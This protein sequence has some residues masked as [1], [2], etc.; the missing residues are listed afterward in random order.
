MAKYDRRQRKAEY[1]FIIYP[2]EYTGHFDVK[3]E[4]GSTWIITSR[5]VEKYLNLPS[6]NINPLLQY[7]EVGAGLGEFTPLVVRNNPI[8]KPIVIDPANYPLMLDLLRSAYK[9]N[10]KRELKE[11]IGVLQERCETLLNPHK[12]NLINLTLE[13]ALEQHPELNGIADV[14]VD[15]FGAIHYSSYTKEERRQAI[16]RE[17]RLTKSG[18][19]VYIY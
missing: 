11:R 16:F 17:R 12:V 2:T 5:D 7:L 13:Q 19:R 14:V 10:L 6:M 4:D 9:K 15:N 18:R 1:T 8:N 3:A